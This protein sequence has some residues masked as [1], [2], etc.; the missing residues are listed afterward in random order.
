MYKRVDLMYERVYFLYNH[1]FQLIL[2][3]FFGN[4]LASIIFK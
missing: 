1:T 4:N 2:I 3:S